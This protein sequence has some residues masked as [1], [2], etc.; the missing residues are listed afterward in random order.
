V[1]RGGR[2]QNPH[3]IAPNKKWQPTEKPGDLLDKQVRQARKS[4]KREARGEGRCWRL[5]EGMQ[6]CKN[7]GEA[8]TAENILNKTDSRK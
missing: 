1:R 8:V 3:F 2:R 7:K 4:R 6:D 5:K